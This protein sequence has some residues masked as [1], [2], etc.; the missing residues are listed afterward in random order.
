[1]TEGEVCPD[2]TKLAPTGPPRA[3]CPPNP[4]PFGLESGLWFPD[5]ACSA[6]FGTGVRNHLGKV[7]SDGESRLKW[8]VTR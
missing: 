2:E 8:T 7:G 4:V 6:I 3:I 5:P 1:M